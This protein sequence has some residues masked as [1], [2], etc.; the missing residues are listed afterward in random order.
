MDNSEIVVTR[1][2]EVFTR[3]QFLENQKHNKFLNNI[4]KGINNSKKKPKEKNKRKE[5]TNKIEK[6]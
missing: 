1:Y 2:G 3:E 6:K 5:T 4:I